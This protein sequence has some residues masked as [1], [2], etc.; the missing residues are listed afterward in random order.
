MEE[1]Y[2]HSCNAKAVANVDA[3]ARLEFFAHIWTEIGTN[4][5]TTIIIEQNVQRP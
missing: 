1:M 4:I 5:M 3:D 2:E